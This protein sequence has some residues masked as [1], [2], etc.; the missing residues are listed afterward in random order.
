MTILEQETTGSEYKYQAWCAD[1]GLIALV[2][3]L[4]KI[5]PKSIARIRSLA[6]EHEL[7]TDHE[8]TLTNQTK[9]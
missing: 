1:C 4:F 9:E 6:E 3:G 5:I 7:L 8:V 2:S